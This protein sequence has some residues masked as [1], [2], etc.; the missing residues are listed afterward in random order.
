VVKSWGSRLP[1]ESERRPLTAREREILALLAKGLSGAA[2]AEQLVLS[3]ETVRTHVRNA[4][5]K[6]GAST[7]SQAVAMVLGDGI[8]SPPDGE[9]SA[10]PQAPAPVGEGGRRDA[11]VELAAGLTELADI[12]WAAVYL[13]DETGMALRLSAHATA[14]SVS[15]APPQEAI[16][17]DGAIG[18]IALRKRSHLVA[19]PDIPS[20]PRGPLLGAPL[21]REGRCV[22]VLCLAVRSSRPVTRR[23][24]LLLDAFANRLAEVLG[25]PEDPAQQL[26]S[27]RRLFTT[28]WIRAVGR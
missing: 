12:D 3:P 8:I 18:R 13:V 22:G 4:M 19:S 15:A 17:G 10:A 1:T 26:R 2:I 7:R 6:L 5:T 20:V 21:V 28:S 16:L 23:E 24:M 25:G 9:P 11:L 14:P 27:A